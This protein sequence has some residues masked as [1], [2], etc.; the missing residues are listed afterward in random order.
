M[1]PRLLWTL[2][3]RRYDHS[4]FFILL[5]IAMV[6]TI[7]KGYHECVKS[8]DFGYLFVQTVFNLFCIYRTTESHT[9]LKI[10]KIMFLLT[11]LCVPLCPLS[12]Q[13]RTLWI[14][15]VRVAHASLQPT[16][17]PPSRTQ[18]V[19]LWFKMGSWWNRARISS[20]STSRGRTTPSSPLRW[21][22]DGQEQQCTCSWSQK[23]QILQNI[24]YNRSPVV[25]GLNFICQINLSG[26]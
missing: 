20:S 26:I 23:R 16:G 17:C 9:C 19:Q 2:R 12:R 1:K 8:M 15:H 5:Y 11:S 18:T 13:C 25:A 10:V 14:R 6:T 7:N 4:S 24:P 3:V 21:V 22:T